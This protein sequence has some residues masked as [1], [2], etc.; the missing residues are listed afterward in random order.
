M[1]NFRCGRCTERIQ[2]NDAEGGHAVACPR[3][4]HVNI[5]PEPSNAAATAPVVVPPP[6]SR[7]SFVPHILWTVVATIAVAGVA[8]GIWSA[9]SEPAASAAP[10]IATSPVD[11]LQEQLLRR[12]VEKPGDPLLSRMYL[13][14]NS[15]YFAS[16]LP[17][18]PVLWEP[19]LAD[20][21]KLA[22]QAFTLEGMFGH[23]GK[24]SVI[25]LNPDLQNDE[26]AL[27]RALCHEIVHAFLFSTGDTTTAH[28]AAFQSVLG[29]L[30]VEGAF[31]GIL[32]TD[33]Q[34]K[35]LRAWL[36]AESSRLDT[37]R[38]QM[39]KVAVDIDAERVVVERALADLAARSSDPLA[40]GG[41]PTEAEVNAVMARRDAYN[42]NA[43][44]ANARAERD[45]AD[46]EQFNKEVARYN[47]MLVYPDGIDENALLKAKAPSTRK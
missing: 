27:D 28:G 42:S 17:V 1:V 34:R 47:L 36:D 35:N 16:S 4:Q 10:T 5:C 8:W 40:A 26:R 45:R 41:R 25:L 30:S 32:A 19:G 44:D 37:E 2:A 11:A 14:I 38:E 23:I 7:A 18:I 9:F 33:E 24:H 12:N 3:C 43:M 29:R 15:K 31:E 39:G 21:G 13:D 6:Q 20:V 46:L 22:R